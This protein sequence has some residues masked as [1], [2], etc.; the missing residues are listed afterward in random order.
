MFSDDHLR[1]LELRLQ[2]CL[3][4]EAFEEA[5]LLRDRIKELR[6]GEQ[7]ES[8]AKPEPQGPGIGGSIFMAKPENFEQW[9]ARRI[10]DSAKLKDA[11]A[12]MR[13]EEHERHRQTYAE[14]QQQMQAAILTALREQI[15]LHFQGLEYD[16]YTMRGQVIRLIDHRHHTEEYS[17]HRTLLLVVHTSTVPWV[18]TK[19]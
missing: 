7:K 11:L 14:M 2:R 3:K 17:L 19:V 1:N 13:K 12:G 6:G 15:A 4:A 16:P 9:P 8:P 10:W 18:I 5:A